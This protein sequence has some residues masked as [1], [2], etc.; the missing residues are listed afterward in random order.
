MSDRPRTTSNPPLSSRSVELLLDLVEIKLAA[1]H[2]EDRDVRTIWHLKKCR[3][4]LKLLEN[5]A[6]TGVGRARQTHVA[7]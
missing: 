1:M 2:T 3:D 7:A 4:E 6:H 5:A